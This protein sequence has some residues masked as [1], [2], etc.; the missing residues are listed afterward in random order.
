M[1]AITASSSRSR[2]P[3]TRWWKNPWRKPRILE[4]FTWGYIAWALL[5]V[6]V[7]ILFSFNGGRSRSA[8]QGFS[9]QWWVAPAPGDTE[10]LFSRPDLTHALQQSVLYALL[11]MLIAVPLGV[12]FAIGIDRWH[13]RGS[14]TANFSMLFS[15]VVPEII[16]GVSLYLMFT[17]LLSTVLGLGSVAQTIGLV[18]FQISYP[19]II[20]RARMLSIGK[21]YEEA[22]MDLGATPTRAVRRILLPM[23]YPAIFASAAI[24]F[25]D[26]LDD[27]VIVDSLKSGAATET[28]A[29]KI[30]SVSRG[31]P[32]PAINAGATLLLV[33]S[34]VVVGLGLLGYRR[35]SKGQREGDATSFVQL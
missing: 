28:F 22:A 24:V 35:F 26:A 31:S 27:F 33:V 8:W 20:V 34:L 16:L 29:T 32:T 18:T 12:L 15:F 13:G 17:N 4:A 3:L 11:T 23:L 10:A 25:A 7:A 6:A 21:E 5:P 1:S 30:Y 9:L 2:N 19:V 14:G